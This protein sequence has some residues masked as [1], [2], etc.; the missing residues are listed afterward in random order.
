M[1]KSELR[2]P[3]A[4]VRG[5][6]SAKAGTGHFIGQRVTALMLMPLT[7]WFISCML[8]MAIQPGGQTPAQ[9][10]SSG[11]NA[12]AMVVMLGAL[13]YHMKLGLQTIIEDYVHCHCIKIAALL[14]N[15]FVMIAFGVVSI[16][17][18]L[19]LHFHI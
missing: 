13:F 17:A 15:Y 6:G 14:I 2:S 1:K 11:F 18:V 3:L 5:L 16:L 12:A 4:K 19:K 7:W 10:L 9:W 8:R